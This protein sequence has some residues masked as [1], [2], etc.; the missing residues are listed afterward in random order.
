MPAVSMTTFDEEV[1]SLLTA[2]LHLSVPIPTGAEK[3]A[4]FYNKYRGPEAKE[5]YLRISDR[6]LTES[7]AVWSKWCKVVDAAEDIPGFIE[8]FT[9]SHGVSPGG[10]FYV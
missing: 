1:S 7:D 2:C 4:Q 5:A 9:D 3:L 6:A 10:C 8:D